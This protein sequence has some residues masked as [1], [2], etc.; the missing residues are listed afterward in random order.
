MLSFFKYHLHAQQAIEL[1][2]DGIVNSKVANPPKENTPEF[3]FYKPEKQKNDK[4]F[5]IIPGGGYAHVAMGHEGHDVAK[6]LKDLGYASFVLKYRLPK[7]TEQE[8]KRIVPI[9]DA[10]KALAY[11]RNQAQTLGIDANKVGVIGFSAGGHLASTL[12]THF[13][14]DYLLANSD[15]NLLRPDFSVLVYPVISMQDELTHQGSKNNL[16]GPNPAQADVVRFSNE[17]NVNA[18]TPPT[19]LVHSEDDKTVPI[20]NSYRYQKA[21]EKYQIPNYLFFY[22]SGIHGFGLVNKQDSRDWF[23]AMLNWVENLK[24]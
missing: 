4:V 20:E 21:L 2:P 8:D 14:T 3:Y 7:A 5:L 1:Y 6:K 18:D 9:Q 10:Q 12:S 23:S 11:I 22:K 17:L 19:F 24:F 16:I 13:G 15:G